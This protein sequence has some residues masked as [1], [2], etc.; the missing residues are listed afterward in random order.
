MISGL[1]RDLIGHRLEHVGI[2]HLC[3]NDLD[4]GTGRRVD[5]RRGLRG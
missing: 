2:D 4:R 1:L 5:E 3:S